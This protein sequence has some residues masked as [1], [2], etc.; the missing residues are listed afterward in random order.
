[1]GFYLK[2]FV[3]PYAFLREVSPPIIWECQHIHT[4]QGEGAYTSRQQNLNLNCEFFPPNSKD[5]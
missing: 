4:E 1:M 5:Q 2:N 3:L